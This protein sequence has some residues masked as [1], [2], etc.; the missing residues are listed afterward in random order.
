MQSDG[1]VNALVEVSGPKGQRG[2]NEGQPV[3]TKVAVNGK[4]EAKKETRISLVE[5]LDIVRAIELTWA[6]SDWTPSTTK[7]GW[8]WDG[9]VLLLISIC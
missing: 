9:V 1:G 8:A 7:T 4:K 5:G 2:K 6:V 3:E